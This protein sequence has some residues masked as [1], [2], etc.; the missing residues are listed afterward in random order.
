MVQSSMECRKDLVKLLLLQ[1]DVVIEKITSK[2]RKI[3]YD[4]HSKNFDQTHLQMEES[5]QPLITTLKIDDIKSRKLQIK[6]YKE[7]NTKWRY[8]SETPRKIP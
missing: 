5:Q 1:S 8:V 3:L 2:F 4:E 6:Y 7:I